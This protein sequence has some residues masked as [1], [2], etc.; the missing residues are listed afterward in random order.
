MTRGPPTCSAHAALSKAVFDVCAMPSRDGAFANLD[1]Y[2]HVTLLVPALVLL[3]ACPHCV[4]HQTAAS[5]CFS[6]AE[7][8]WLGRMCDYGHT[9]RQS[10]YASCA[11]EAMRPKTSTRMSIFS[12]LTVMHALLLC[13]AACCVSCSVD[14]R[15]DTCVTD[16]RGRCPSPK[17]HLARS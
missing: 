17:Q 13:A 9:R 8:T 4:L 7:A 16:R 10:D 1:P 11:G 2:G 14:F 15:Q 12:C 5:S 3:Q 6:L